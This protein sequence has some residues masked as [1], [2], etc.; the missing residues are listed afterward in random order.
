M[1]D[2]SRGRPEPF[3]DLVEARRLVTTL[4]VSARP[5]ATVI[6]D[7]NVVGQAPIARPIFVDAG[8][9]TIRVELV[10]FKPARST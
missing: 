6:V 10:G 5:G 9:H 8:R 2:E 7:G 4:R 1:L 3:F